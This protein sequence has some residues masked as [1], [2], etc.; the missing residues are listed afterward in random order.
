L[1]RLPTISSTRRAASTSTMRSL[2]PANESKSLYT[3]A[4]SSS[5]CPTRMRHR[6]AGAGPRCRLQCWKLRSRPRQA[7]A[8]SARAGPRRR[9]R[10]APASGAKQRSVV[11]TGLWR[12]QLPCAAEHT[13]HSG[14]KYLSAARV[15]VAVCACRAPEHPREESTL[16]RAYAERICHADGRARFTRS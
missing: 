11:V 13:M 1:S 9:R 2:S 3:A 4:K 8:A 5:L 12:R 14:V 7:R 10:P 15:E 16:A 6:R